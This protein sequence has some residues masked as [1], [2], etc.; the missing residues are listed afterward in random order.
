MTLTGNVYNLTPA[1]I[2][3]QNDRREPI[4]FEFTPPPGADCTALYWDIRNGVRNLRGEI[5]PT[6]LRRPFVYADYL[7]Y[8]RKK[9]QTFDREHEQDLQD[10]LAKTGGVYNR[11]EWNALRN[12]K[13]EER[14][15][16]RPSYPV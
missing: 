7:A 8:Y 10:Y 5:I 12:K 14:A 16:T 4:A 6:H 15:K 11:E 2:M 3:R 9:I 13:I 1:S